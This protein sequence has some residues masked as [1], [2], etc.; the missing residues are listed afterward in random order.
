RREAFAINDLYSVSSHFLNQPAWA[1]HLGRRVPGDLGIVRIDALLNAT[2]C[3]VAEVQ[4]IANR[5]PGARGIRALRATMDLV[6]GGA[7][8]PKETELRL[9]LVRDGLPRPATQ[10]RV[11]NRR[12]DMGWCQWK[13]G[14]EYDG[15]QHW[16]SPDI[17][18]G[19]IERLEFLAAQGWLIVRVSARHLRYQ[20][21]EIVRRVCEALRS[22][23]CPV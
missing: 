19:D 3:T 14:V 12:I 15:V 17:H 22:R 1:V 8:S 5:Y 2:G 6:D 7:E 20:R 11:G 18:A 13:V 4:G 21:A 10:I 9:L 16:T 23:G